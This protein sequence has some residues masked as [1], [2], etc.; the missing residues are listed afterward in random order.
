MDLRVVA[1]LKRKRGNT[2]N[3]SVV[4][5][6]SQTE[7]NSPL[8]WAFGL[9]T[10][11]GRKVAFSRAKSNFPP[12]TLRRQIFIRLAERRARLQNITQT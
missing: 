5:P 4:E 2:T 6:H 12:N 8:A 7:P 10:L 9:I 1:S 11:A 3:E